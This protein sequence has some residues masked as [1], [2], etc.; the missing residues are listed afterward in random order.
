M[1]RMAA[2]ALCVVAGG[3][4]A[5]GD[6]GAAEASPYSA[7]VAL[8][9]EH[10]DNVFRAPPGQ[11]QSDR[12]TIAQLFGDIDQRYGRH[13]LLAHASL[14][15]NQYQARR[16]LNN[17][18]YRARLGWTGSTEGEISWNLSHETERKLASYGTV[19]DPAFRGANIETLDQTLA[20][21]QLGLQAKW[22]VNLALGHRRVQHTA[23][24]F[25]LEQITQ[26]SAGIGLQW[27]PLGPVSASVGPRFTRGRVPMASD[28]VDRDFERRDIDFGLHW[29]V[30]GQSA[31][32]ARLSLTQQ[33]Q[34]AA[35]GGDFNG[36]T[37]QLDWQWT[38]SGKTRVNVA[39]SRETGSETTF[40]AP[41][42]GAQTLRGSGDNSQL[43]TALRAQA[44][45]DLTGKI[46]LGLELQSAHRE[47]AASSLAGDGSILRSSGSDRSTLV[48]LGLRYAPTRSTALACS[49]G[50][51]RR[52]SQ[53][54]LSQGY[55]ATT[56]GCNAQLTL[57]WS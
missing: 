1:R 57:R 33:S 26:D 21:A 10:D 25:E 2:A 4:V 5:Q 18:G 49:L 15:D 9:L 19:R 38:V 12:H 29:T 8:G 42:G 52:E 37:G 3:A 28:G 47:L 50:H 20:G 39:L 24:A 46:A 27:N 16:E 11:T 43:T 56:A 32:H 55:R 30:T 14:R 17:L 13:R 23:Q 7:G 36:A 45:H 22:V 31:L 35:A 53:T 54:P 48:R 34:A 51:E 41:A 6:P 40:F 44:A